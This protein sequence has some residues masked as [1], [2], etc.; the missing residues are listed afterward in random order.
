MIKCPVCQAEHPENTL[1]CDECGSYL[2][3]GDQKETDPLAA[4]EVT[5]ME[6]EETTEIPEEEVASPVSLKLSIPDSG[7]DVE[8]PLTKEV[9]IGR[10]DPAS[11]SFPDIDLTNDG[12]LEKGVSRRHAKITRRGSEVLIEDLGSINGTFLNRKKLTPYLPQALKNGD[13]LQLGKLILQ[14]N[15]Q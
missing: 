9:N 2:Q 1:F 10:L 12:G 14:V 13:E 8:L 5:W 11:A 15:F 7:R 4:A 6:R 3:G